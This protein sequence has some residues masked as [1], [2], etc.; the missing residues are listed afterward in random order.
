MNLIDT[1]GHV[2]FTMEVERSLRVLDGGI[3]VLDSSAGVEA[4]TITVW[5]QASKYCVPRIAFLNK[6]DKPNADFEAS[7]ES[8]RT[9]LGSEPLLIQRPIGSGK[10]FRGIIDIVGL[11]RLV[12]DKDNNHL[13]RN[14]NTIPVTAA[15]ENAVKIMEERSRLIDTL[16]DF[17]D[18]LAASVIETGDYNSVSEEAV[19]R[20]LRKLTLDSRGG[21]NYLVTLCGSAYKNIGVQP[22][23]DSAVRL[24]PSPD[25]VPK[26]FLRHYSRDDLVAL[27]FKTTHHPQK[28]LLTFVRVYSGKISEGQTV[29][30]LGKES[31]EKVGKLMVA[32]A[33]DF[34]TV[35]EIGAGGIAVISGLKETVTGDTIVKSKNSGNVAM[36]AWEGS[37][38]SNATCPL[39]SGVSIPDPVFYCSIEPP[40]MRFQKQLDLALSALVREDPS[41]RV[42]PDKDT[43]QTVIAGMGELHID[44]IKDRILRFGNVKLIN[45]HYQ[46]H[47]QTKFQAFQRTQNRCRF[48]TSHDCLQGDGRKS[49]QRN[50]PFRERYNGQ[51]IFYCD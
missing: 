6:M 2:D 24:L 45:I 22:L 51:E 48:R 26:Q 25:D 3:V 36:S 42:W 10:S 9:R 8:I 15:T 21:H 50:N 30:N 27:A 16:C 12:W 38:K 14:Y 33:D 19:Y 44:I 40:S 1:P 5:R 47:Y 43:G 35:R 32:F 4:Q 13:G 49:C 23:L 31:S 17:D 18:E 39:L 34:R 46:I 41:L 11:K 20:A 7:L 28:G 37:S 29:H